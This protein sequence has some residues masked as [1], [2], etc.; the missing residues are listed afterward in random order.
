MD[1]RIIKVDPAK[2]DIAQLQQVAGIIDAGG[3][4]AFPTETVYGIASRVKSDSLARLGQLK[5][6]D[7][8]KY[9]TLHIGQKGTVEKYVPSISLRTR[10]LIKTAWPGPVTIVFQLSENDIEKQRSTIETEIFD[11]LYKDN[12]IGIRCPDNPIAAAMLQLTQY[13]VVAPSAN[14]AGQDPHTKAEDVIENFAGQ[15]DVLVDGGPCRY[16]K[17][18]SIVKINRDNLEI[19]RQGV[20]SKQQLSEASKVKFLFVCTGNTCR[21]PMA[22]GF[23][24]KFLAEKIGCEVDQLEKKGYIVS[25]AGI[26]GLENVPVS[27]ESVIACM[28]KGIDIAGSRSTAL[29]GQLIAESDF[30]FAMTETHC[31]GIAALDKDA[32]DK[33][34]LLAENRNI[35]DPIG[36]SQEVY[37]ICAGLIEE[38]V[39]KKVSELLI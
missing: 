14:I 30:I 19:I 15:I 37:G 23:F 7:P 16:G 24:S 10:K 4:V 28:A 9:Y 13:P 36:Q 39:S 6:R 2:P 11:C 12:T 32:V 29:T 3:L 20:Y 33:C 5:N 25:S 38:A 17:S 21:S 1:M 35:P 18:S 22:E 31:R 26:M 8:D 27:T 34:V